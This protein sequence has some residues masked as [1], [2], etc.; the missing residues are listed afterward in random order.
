MMKVDA[1]ITWVDGD[2]K[3]HRA[4]RFRYGSNEIFKE[5]DKAGDTRF[6]S[7]GEIFWCVASLNRF[8]PWLNKIYIVTDGQD[9]HLEDFLAENFPQG[10]I[11]VEIVDHK[12]IFRGYEQYL[13]TFNSISIETMTWRIPGLSDRF[14][15]LNDDM[16][17]LA[18]VNPH[19]FFLED[20]R[21]VWY[22]DSYSMHWT[23]FTRMLK[24][25]G[26]VTFKG[27]M[28]NAA[29]LAGARW[30]FFKLNHAPRA[31]QRGFYERLFTE[32]PELVTRNISHR[33]RNAVQ[34]TPQEYQL[35]KLHYNGG[36]VVRPVRPYLFFV[37][38]KKGRPEY[39]DE[40]L[41]RLEESKALFACFNSIDLAAPEQ[42]V[43][44]AKWIENRLD[45]AI[46]R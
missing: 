29:K 2:D 34:F 13:P 21:S 3:A 9:P 12:T 10:Y 1:V 33:F 18:P 37:Q 30:R 15:E 26:K 20:G 8:A 31:L 6:S 11:P 46:R 23:R 39:L 43:R 25:K 41:R 44:L 17:L 14:I 27:V 45:I 36:C 32:F 35:M 24:G 4:K 28:Y 42:R 7:L 5:E 38:P 22:A 40:K 19:D 16:M